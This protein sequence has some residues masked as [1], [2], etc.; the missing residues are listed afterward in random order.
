[1]R[2]NVSLAFVAFLVVFVGLGCTSEDKR[3][4]HEAMREWRG[5]NIKFGSHDRTSP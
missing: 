4:W 2:R 3:Q 5:D 1:M